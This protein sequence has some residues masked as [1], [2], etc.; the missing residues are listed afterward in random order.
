MIYRALLPLL[1]LTSHLAAAELQWIRV[2]DDGKK[3]VRAE[4]GALFI[5]WGFNY[6]HEGDGKLLEDYWDD[7]WPTVEAAFGEMKMLGANVVRIHLQFGR[8]MESPTEPRQHALDQLARLVLL[9]EQTELYLDLTG[10]GCYHKQDV[11][12]W[13]DKLSEEDRWAAQAVFWEAVAKT[14]AASPAIFCYDLMNE[15]VVPGG[16]K[17]RDDWLGPGFGGKHFVQFIAL[18]RKNR[19]RTDIAREW[20]RLLASAIRKHDKQHLVT[21]GLVPWS[22]DRPG[23]TSGFVPE[24]IADELDFIAM[25]IYPESGKLGEAVET[26]KGFAAV[27]KPVVIEETFTLKCGADELERFIDQSRPYATGWIGFYWGKTP[28]EIRPAKTIPEALTLG[29]LELFQKKRDEIVADTEPFLDNGVTA[30]RGNSGSFPENTMPAFQSG[31][32]LGADWIELDILRTRD[33][34]LVVIHDPTTKRVGDQDRVVA[35]TTYEQLS[36]IDVATDFRRRNDKS[37]EECPV[38]RIPLLKE[39]LQQV[40]T[41]NQTRVSIQ[42]KMDCV[43]DAVALVIEMNAERWVGFNDGN[44]DYMAHVKRLAPTIPVF[45][46]RGKQTN[47]DEDIAIAKQHG[48]E[49]LVVHHEGITSEK[50]QKIKAAG[51]AV[52]AWTVNDPDTMKRLLKLGVERI[53]T[54]HPRLLLSLRADGLVD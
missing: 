33:G 18:D 8:F 39:V 20:I 10:L 48:F 43:A 35:E 16:D 25:H 3:F 28:D 37:V 38:Q 27:G 34:R 15:P 50:V 7:Q 17:R 14:C 12:A 41:Q 5:P 46:D 30:H 9:A 26:V 42:P 44:L 19:N 11:P 31:I 2:S 23:M 36:K 4:S 40:M 53:Y 49:A 13:Y 29:W 24:A 6:D 51:I 32:D 22:L 45:W 1:V 54:D 21:V 52:G 47:I